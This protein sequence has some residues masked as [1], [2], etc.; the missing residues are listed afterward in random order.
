MKTTGKSK[1]ES[2]EE[3]DC[4]CGKPVKTVGTKKP[5]KAPPWAKKAMPL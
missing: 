2:H 1:P 3:A 4:Y 5:S